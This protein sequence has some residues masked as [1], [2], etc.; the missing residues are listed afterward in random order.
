MTYEYRQDN[1]SNNNSSSSSSYPE[2]RQIGWIAQDMEQIVP[3]VVVTNP[4]SGY[5]SIA[6]SHVTPLLVE[7][8]KAMQSQHEEEMQ[9][10]RKEYDT[11]LQA[12]QNT[13]DQLQSMLQQ[14]LSAKQE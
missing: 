10:L 14:L 5:K 3:E 8:M 11:K 7:A 13:V 1:S 12:M 2:G 9:I 4:M 6:Y